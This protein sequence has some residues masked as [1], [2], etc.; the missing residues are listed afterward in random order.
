MEL[1]ITR[2]HFFISDCR[3]TRETSQPFFKEG[4]L[5]IPVFCQ[6]IFREKKIGTSV[7]APLSP[8]YSTSL[9]P[10]PIRPLVEN[11][12]YFEV[13]AIKNRMQILIEE[14]A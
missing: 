1:I 9:S 8:M 7:T 6:P 5:G 4:F 13:P 2:E 10:P 11:Y 14:C 12:P 3:N